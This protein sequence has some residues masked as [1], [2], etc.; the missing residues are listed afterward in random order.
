MR[1]LIATSLAQRSPQKLKCVISA[2]GEWPI[3][4]V[5]ADEVLATIESMDSVSASELCDFIIALSRDT[6]FMIPRRERTRSN[7]IQSTRT[8]KG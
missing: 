7:P 2:M 3:S 8:A 5:V 6:Q 4:D 1:N